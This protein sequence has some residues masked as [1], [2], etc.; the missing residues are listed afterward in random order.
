M[1]GVCI[2]ILHT[3]HVLNSETMRERVRE[4]LRSRLKVRVF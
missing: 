3:V 2:C 1:N 4:H